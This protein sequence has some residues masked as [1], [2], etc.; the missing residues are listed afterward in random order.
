MALTFAK[1]S[2]QGSLIVAEKGYDPAVHEYTCWEL[3]KII[4]ELNLENL[5]HMDCV[6]N[7]IF[8]YSQCKEILEKEIPILLSADLSVKA[9]K[10]VKGLEYALSDITDPFNY[11]LL[12]GD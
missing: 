1:I 6:L 11:L 7:I 10:V 9:R 5:K 4:K 12:E 2:I 8:N 3:M